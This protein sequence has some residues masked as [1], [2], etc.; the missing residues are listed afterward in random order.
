MGGEREKR[1]RPTASRGAGEGGHSELKLLLLQGPHRGTQAWGAYHSLAGGHGSQQGA[2]GA[3]T[4][5]RSEPVW[6][7]G[8][9]AHN[10]RH[11]GGT[12]QSRAQGSGTWSRVQTAPP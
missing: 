7:T 8:R 10:G 2:H 11:L 4:G 3:G 6:H 5:G 9:A 12:A 1:E